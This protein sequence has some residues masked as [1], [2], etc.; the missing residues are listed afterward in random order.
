MALYTAKHYLQVLGLRTTTRAFTYICLLVGIIENSAHIAALCCMLLPGWAGMLLSMYRYG[1]LMVNELDV[2][3]WSIVIGYMM[4]MRQLRP[5]WFQKLHE[6]LQDKFV[7][8]I[9]TMEKIK[10]IVSSNVI[11]HIGEL[12]TI[13]LVALPNT[14]KHV[15]MLLLIHAML[16]LDE[17]AEILLRLVS[18]TIK[19]YI[20]NKIHATKPQLKPIR[21]FPHPVFSNSKYWRRVRY[22][23]TKTQKSFGKRFISALLKIHSCIVQ[24]LAYRTQ[25]MKWLHPSTQCNITEHIPSW[26]LTAV[27]NSI[28]HRLN[29]TKETAIH[30][31]WRTQEKPH[32]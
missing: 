19:R 29:K 17:I 25:H 22:Q 1:M 9:P 24:V 28:R 31:V 6:V 10:Q 32:G 23:Y 13:L 21:N 20:A 15:N 4:H 3:R 2:L 8:N 12:A 11:R 30:V 26:S 14:S 16:I 27:I 7:V 18:E 5:L